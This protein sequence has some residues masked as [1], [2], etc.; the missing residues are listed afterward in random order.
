VTK[1]KNLQDSL[2]LL[3]ILIKLYT[4]WVSMLALPS[5]VALFLLAKNS[6]I[7]RDVSALL[8]TPTGHNSLLMADAYIAKNKYFARY[9]TS[10]L[11][12]NTIPVCTISYY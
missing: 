12:M 6:P 4:S 3:C 10:P 5:V 8:A 7:I 1:L 2:V 9:L 11:P